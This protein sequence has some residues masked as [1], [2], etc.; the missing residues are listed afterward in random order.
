M[1]QEIYEAFKTD[2]LLQ[3]EMRTTYSWFCRIWNIEFP[4][5]RILKRSQFSTCA[6]CT[7]FKALYDKA[8]LEAKRSKCFQWEF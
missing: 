4:R 5:V 3:D 2:T 8:T 7:E 6:P 1:K